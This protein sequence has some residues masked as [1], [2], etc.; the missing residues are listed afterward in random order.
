MREHIEYGSSG[1]TRW[2]ATNVSYEV[3]DNLNNSSCSLSRRRTLIASLSPQ[4]LIHMYIYVSTYIRTLYKCVYIYIYMAEIE[5]E[6]GLLA[7]EK[8]QTDK[9][10]PRVRSLLP[11][12]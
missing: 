9:R 2:K 6:S 3:L 8:S 4:D 1:K 11:V 12:V 10:A 7:I 5:V